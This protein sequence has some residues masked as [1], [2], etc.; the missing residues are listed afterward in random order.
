MTATIGTAA[1]IG[2]GSMGS[3]IAAQFAN[4]GIPVLLM[5]VAAT[6]GPRNAAAEAGI[7]RQ[8]K[9]GGF[10]HP[11]RAALVTPCNTEDDMSRLREADWIV[12]AVVEDLA[13]KRGLFARVDAARSPASIVSSN[14]STI[15]LA[16]MIE[17]QS[18]RFARDFLITHFF[19]PPRVMQLLEV[20]AGPTTSEAA[21]ATIMAAGDEVLGKTVL[22]CRDTPGFVANRIGCFWIAVA[23]IE[24]QRLGLTIEE[25]DAIAGAPFRI[26]PIGPFGVLDL[27]GVDL[28][29]HVWGSLQTLLPQSDLL[30]AYNLTAEPLVRRMIERKLLGRK[31]G[32]GFYRLNREGGK[33]TRDVLDMATCEFRPERPV[34][35]P[36]LTAHGRD[37]RRLCEQDD[38]AGRYA[39]RV[40]SRLVQYSAA[41]GPDIAGSAADVDLGMRLGYGWSE[42]PFQIADRVG[43][44]W[45]AQRLRAEGGAVP[46]LLADA[47]ASGGFYTGTAALAAPSGS[48]AALQ[49]GVVFE[50][51]GAA[52]LDIG[53][54]VACLEHRTKMNVFS[55]EVFD[56]LGVALAEVPKH[57]RALVIGSDHPRAFS[58]GADLSVLLARIRSADWAAIE[59]FLAIGQERF[60][61]LK[62]AAFPVVGAAFGLA[63]GGGC[64]VLL[65]CRE[66]VAHADLTIG[67]PEASVG[68]IPGWGGCTQLLARWA[69]KPGATQG[70]LA[71]AT[72]VFPLILG[73]R[74]STS[75]L[76]AR[77]FAALREEDGIVMSRRKLLAAAKAR[78]LAL[79]GTPA[80]APE[81]L[82][83][84]G[85]L[86][87]A[88]LM[89]AAHSQASLGQ[90]SENDLAIAEV[91]ATVLSGGATDPLVAM[92][93][94]QVDALARE[95]VLTLARRPATVAR[96][97]HTLATGKPLRN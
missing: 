78:A 6:T 45:I 50:T 94:Q 7:A 73:S 28:V 40:L 11:R 88:A 38:A 86:G 20:V 70:P 92:T 29:P 2:A 10:M 84:P 14:T 89:G 66:V 57:F 93:E 69:R 58:A 62:Y 97:E 95:A 61:A 4:A 34:D 27:V 71:P 53:D 82:F 49:R 26:P 60:L 36:S 56:V 85:P 25:A 33:R 43:A 52:L 80:A 15:P 22:A 42:G 65:H 12:E 67:L 32:A 41:V 44:A 96:I 3:G 47:A 48:L 79:A 75:A 83:L 51:A 72:A 31:S 17:G 63:L 59:A 81:A 24:A 77:D 35:L 8:L 46:R 16:K 68:L 18:Q 19:N 90:Q 91:L 13:I 30:W 87:K 37:L 5:D 9:A 23:I 39:W 21:A 55:P 74:V 54:G 64:E 76:E 1:V